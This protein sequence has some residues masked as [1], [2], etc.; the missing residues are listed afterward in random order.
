M[1]SAVSQ[2]SSLRDP[3]TSESALG[4]LLAPP[5]IWGHG[6]VAPGGPHVG[7]AAMVS[8]SLPQVEN[9]TLSSQSASLTAQY[10][11]FQN[12]QAAKE[13]EHENLQKQQER[14]AAA[15]EAL[16][17]DHEHLGALHE[18]QAAEY[19]ALIRQHSCLKTLHRSLELEHRELGERC[20]PAAVGESGGPWGSCPTST[21]PP[22][23]SWP[24]ASLSGAPELSQREVSVTLSDLEFVQLETE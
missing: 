19:E 16:L 18:R 10:T 23:S 13:T 20:V 12:Q 22:V 21:L 6:S 3:V 15:Y 14:L 1:S 5:R 17:Q 24:T 8:S 7:Q 2:S 4:L 9:S 11:L